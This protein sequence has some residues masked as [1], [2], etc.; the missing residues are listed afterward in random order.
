MNLHYAS[1]L[2]SSDTERGKGDCLTWV[3]YSAPWRDG[4]SSW[5]LSSLP[6][7]AQQHW[8][9]LQAVKAVIIP[10]PIFMPKEQTLG[11]EVAHHVFAK[12]ATRCMF[13]SGMGAS[14][15]GK[16]WKYLPSP[17]A[18]KQLT[19][20][21]F[22]VLPFHP[23]T[24]MVCTDFPISRAYNKKRHQ[25]RQILPPTLT[26]GPGCTEGSTT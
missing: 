13:F 19:T 15:W 23:F 20:G 12:D 5:W 18:A 14:P 1:V 8:W 17:D 9:S 7:C 2:P 6:S 21:H 3:T 24:F 26:H 22:I 10:G 11:L 16:W 4:E 25:G